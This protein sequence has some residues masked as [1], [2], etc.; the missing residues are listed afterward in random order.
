MAEKGRVVVIGSG[1]AGNAA[2][3]YLA[4]R[5]WHVVQVERGKWG[6]TCLW[7]GCIPKKSL[8]RSASI[9]RAMRDADRFGVIAEPQPLDW[10]SVLAWKWHAQET[11]AGDQEGL[12]A[13]YGIELVHGDARF[14]SEESVA[15]GDRSFSADHF[16]IATGSAP[17]LP[18][19]PGVELADT[20]EDA[21]RYPEI[22][23]SLVIV[24]GGFIAMEMAG[25]YASFG[26][27][28]TVATRPE[29]VLDMLDAEL[30]E[31]AVR[32]LSGLGVQFMTGCSVTAIEGQA[33][34]LVVRATDAKG[35]AGALEAERVIM[36]VGRRP[37]VARLD[38]DAAGV[39]TDGQGHIVVDEYLRTTNPQVWAA[40]DAA[41]GMMQTPVANLEG[42]TVGQSI[43]EGIPTHPD[44]WA[45]PITCFTLPQLATVGDTEQAARDRGVDVKVSRV[46][47]GI[48]GA[49]IVDGE[50]D[51]FLKI[52]VDSATDKILGCQIASP[53]ASDIAYA[54]AIA[55]RCGQTAEQLG[56]AV[57]I[58]PSHAEMLFYAGG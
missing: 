19:I 15:V 29:R 35:A 13:S 22:P 27:R 53:T 40:G 36:A 58:H 2:A 48:V 16:V 3:R 52:V 18:A 9:A 7:R 11:F 17:V 32:H 33:G 1:S 44:C 47:L 51:G 8:Y 38:L 10:Q 42:R 57:A 14:T 21:L 54:A 34:A 24:G 37:D 28:V 12:A 30:A 25:I 20:S 55:I 23:Q 39:G 50:T 56:R 46:G 49:P 41:G 6:G 5:D 43:D 45:M 31:T 26:T 4:R